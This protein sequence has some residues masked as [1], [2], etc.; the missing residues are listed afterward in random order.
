MSSSH[1]ATADVSGLR[2]LLQV[3][4]GI[5]DPRDPRGVRHQLVSVLAVAVLTVLGGAANFREIGD[6]AADLPQSVLAL[7]GARF[8]RTTGRYTP[9]SGS[10]VRRLICAIDAEHADRL[11]CA[12]INER[13]ASGM[14]GALAIDGKVVRGAQVTLFAAVTHGQGVVVAHLQAPAATTETTQVQTLLDPLTLTGRVVTADAAHTSRATATYILGRAG[15]YLLPVKGN[16]PSL[17]TQVRTALAGINTLTTPA[18][19]IQEEHIRGQIYRRSLWLADATDIEFPGAAQA[20]LLRRD[21]YDLDGAHRRKQIVHGITSLRAADRTPAAIN[22]YA[23]GHW[24]VEN[25]VHHVRDVTWSE[26][27][28]QTHTETG[29]RMMAALRNLALSILNLHGIT[30]IKATLQHLERRPNQAIALL[31][32]PPT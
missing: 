2:S 17:Q 6:Q 13:T 25:K 21:V 26:D 18:D 27:A 20:F 4:E 30:K 10:T 3:L 31:N 5:A 11:L 14:L 9:A 28:N 1:A 23:R 7:T 32:L 16:T 24:T 8:D 19:H 12:W 15:D 29:P 22:D